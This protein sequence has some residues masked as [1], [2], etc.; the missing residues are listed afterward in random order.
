VRSDIRHLTL[1]HARALA[2]AFAPVALVRQD[3]AFFTGYLAAQEHGD[4]SA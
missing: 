3:L 4:S 1:T 2:A